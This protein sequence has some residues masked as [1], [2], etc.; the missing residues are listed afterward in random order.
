MSQ[1]A[2]ITLAQAKSAP[3]MPDSQSE[4]GTKK[5]VRISAAALKDK[6]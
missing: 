4:L 5:H 3:V 2:L 6:Q 1:P